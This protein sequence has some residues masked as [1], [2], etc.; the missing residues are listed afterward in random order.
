MSGVKNTQA[1]QYPLN[2]ILYSVIIIM[3]YCNFSQL[4]SQQK[5]TVQ[6]WFT[7]FT[8]YWKSVTYSMVNLCHDGQ[9]NFA[10]SLYYLQA[11]IGHIKL[12]S[13]LFEFMINTAVKLFKYPS[14]F[15]K[16]ICYTMCNY[17]SAFVIG[18]NYFPVLYNG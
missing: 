17:V 18:K 10:N 14:T 7:H 8:K 6:I 2:I 1:Q 9:Y 4:R 13:P 3:S 12:F 16:L 15:A 11:D 5:V